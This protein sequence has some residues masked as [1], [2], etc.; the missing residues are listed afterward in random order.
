MSLPAFA[1]F[2]DQV[3]EQYNTL[4][5]TPYWV[6]NYPI[7]ATGGIY[8]FSLDGCPLYV[9][10]TRNLRR[11]LRQHSHKD[12]TQFSASFAFLMARREFLGPHPKKQM[13][14]QLAISKPFDEVFADCRKRVGAMQ[15]RWVVEEDPIVQSLL[16]IYA[17]ATL[18]TTAHFNS[19]RTT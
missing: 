14:H 6:E 9:G 10:R 12:S 13:R 11:R 5:D 8:V 19:F 4:L 7:P 16:E 15:V 1:S 17:A 3:H 2:M 18:G